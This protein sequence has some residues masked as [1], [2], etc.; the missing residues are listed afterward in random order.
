MGQLAKYLYKPPHVMAAT[1][2]RAL[3]LAATLAAAAGSASIH[4]DFLHRTIT[5]QGLHVAATGEGDKKKDDEAIH[6]WEK[7]DAIITSEPLRRLDNGDTR[8]QKLRIHFDTSNLDSVVDEYYQ[9]I[10]STIKKDILPT[11]EETWT[12]ALSVLPVESSL[13]FL[14]GTCGRDI[15][16]PRQYDLVGHK[17][18]DLILFVGGF[19]MGD[20]GCTVDTRAFGSPCLLDAATDRPIVGALWFCLDRLVYDLQLQNV[21]KGIIAQAANHE[22][23][24]VLGMSSVLYPFFRDAS[25]PSLEPRTPDRT[26]KQV[27][28]WD[29]TVRTILVPDS[30]TLRIDTSDDTDHTFS[31]VTPTVAQVVRNH[32]ACQKLDG[33]PLE[34]HNMNSKD[35]FGD[36]W[37]EQLFHTELM[38][39][40]QAAENV[41]SPLTLALL[42]DSGWYKASYARAGISSFGHMAGCD[43][44]EKDCIVDG[45]NIPQYSKGFFCNNTMF[46]RNGELKGFYECDA[47]HTYAAQ[48]DLADH[49]MFAA[50]FQT[51]PP[52]KEY[53]YFDN[54]MIGPVNFIQADYC[55]IVHEN[56]INCKD[57]IGIETVEGETFGS[58]SL[59]YNAKFP[60]LFEGS[61][62]PFA[63]CM[64]SKCNEQSGKLE[65]FVKGSMFVCDFDFQLHPYPGLGSSDTFECP[66]LSVVCPHFMCP[67]NCNGKGVCQDK[68][69]CECFDPSDKTPDCSNTPYYAYL[70]PEKMQELNKAFAA[71]SDGNRRKYGTTAFLILSSMVATATIADLR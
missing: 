12:S 62:A 44:V 71:T 39:G 68:R 18:S 38:G 11:V 3:V 14:D 29:G 50:G 13:Y 48:C 69:R 61:T 28:C 40:T 43:F 35:C 53:Q 25:T 27:T 33:A 64:K 37:D 10:A 19:K 20:A 52:E 51:P 49:S 9:S 41:L 22:M 31:I 67:K 42:E 1:A 5:G 17:G 65:V 7:D 54:P 70:G 21:D 63:T 26:A 8:Y 15:K 56:P 23:G 24:H 34:N 58:D 47:S 45:G 46:V 2:V 30:S 36:H 60:S 32:F 4:D 66:R 16:I 6:A 59:C 57:P 55:P